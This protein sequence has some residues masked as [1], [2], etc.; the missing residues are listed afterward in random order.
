MRAT[1]GAELEDGL[2]NTTI[3]EISIHSALSRIQHPNIAMLLQ[4][5]VNEKA[6]V[7]QLEY[8]PWDLEKYIQQE[9]ITQGI[10][11]R[12]VCMLPP[13]SSRCIMRQILKGIA[14]CH[15]Q[16]Y[17]HRDLKPQNI[18]ITSQGVVKLGD[19][20]LAIQYHPNILLSSNVVTLWYR[21]PELL[22]DW[23]QGTAGFVSPKLYYGFE[24][25]VWSCG[26]IFAELLY[27][28]EPFDDITGVVPLDNHHRQESL[29]KRR[30]RIHREITSGKLFHLE[31]KLEEPGIHTHF[32]IK[33]I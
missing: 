14:F 25:D 9:G 1:N 29:G 11:G 5:G 33:L 7:L 15:E 16:G 4:K 17:I 20:G 18:F 12:N 22:L 10:G 13:G 3:R 23:E 26:C 24:V 6:A 27:G 30:S 32:E 2:Q 19:F 21:A 31:P 8:Y 28:R